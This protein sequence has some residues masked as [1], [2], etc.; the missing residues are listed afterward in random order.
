MKKLQAEADLANGVAPKAPI[1]GGPKPA[2][3]T[4]SAPAFALKPTAPAW[5]KP[6]KK[7]EIQTAK[8][9]EAAAPETNID[10]LVALFV[11]AKISPANAQ[12]YADALAAE[13]F[14]APEKLALVDDADLAAC[15]ITTR[16]DIKIINSLKTMTAKSLPPAA[17]AAAPAAVAKAPAFQR[18]PPPANKAPAMGGVPSQPGKPNF[19]IKKKVVAEAA[20]EPAPVPAGNK[21]NFKIPVK[22]APVAAAAPAAAAPVKAGGLRPALKSAGD[23]AKNKE[24]D[25][26]AFVMSLGAPLDAYKKPRQI[27]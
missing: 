1:G 19:V 3:S 12:K 2:A 11:Q 18:A 7:A 24:A 25:R 5:Q 9:L 13:G 17:A 16:F 27:G 10:A 14:D 20:P 26:L 23:A 22:K 6:I 15:G 4:N 8:K 21:P